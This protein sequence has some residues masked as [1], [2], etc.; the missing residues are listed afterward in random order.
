MPNPGT[1][2]GIQAAVESVCR[3]LNGGGSMHGSNSVNNSM[4][5]G[6]G[7]MGMG[8]VERVGINGSLLTASASSSSSSHSQGSGLSPR[9]SMSMMMMGGNGSGSGSASNSYHGQQVVHHTYTLGILL[10][11]LVVRAKP[12]NGLFWLSLPPSVF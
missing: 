6:G 7:G 2:E 4:H 12:L 10:L 9:M 11:I 8:M 5:G 1:A 3:V